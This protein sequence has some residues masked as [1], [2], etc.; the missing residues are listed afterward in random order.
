MKKAKSILLLL[1]LSCSLMSF[2]STNSKPKTLNVNT[3]TFKQY[4]GDYLYEPAE[5]IIKIFTKEK[6]NH[7]KLYF[8][9]PREPES[10]LVATGEHKFCFKTE[11]GFHVEFMNEEN[12]VFKELTL[13]QP[14]GNVQAVRK[15][16]SEIDDLTTIDKKLIEKNFSGVVLIAQFLIGYFQQ[17][18]SY[19]LSL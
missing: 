9:I 1:M 17:S 15:E 11:E 10:E 12:G 6:E 2:S 14:H 13:I 5:I 3:S 7:T 19:Y 16:K 4:V 8:S 18:K